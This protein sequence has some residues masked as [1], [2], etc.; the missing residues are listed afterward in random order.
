[1]KMGSA[2]RKLRAFRKKEHDA[3][4]SLLNSFRWNLELF[5]T[6]EQAI[7]ETEHTGGALVHILVGSLLD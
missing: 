2:Y 7:K 3:L 1:M 6:D 5:Y 4:H